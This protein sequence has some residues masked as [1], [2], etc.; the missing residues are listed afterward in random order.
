MKHREVFGEARWLSPRSNLDAAL[1]R[2]EIEIKNDFQKA[3]L[4]VCGL[5]WFIFFINGKRVGS[6]EFVPAYSDYHERPNM[7]LVYPLN[8]EQTHRI[9]VMKYDV[10]KYLHTG[11]NILAAAV[12]GGYYHQTVRKA[13]G[14]MNYGAIKL[15]YK[16]DVDGE[17]FYSNRKD[18]VF[19]SGFF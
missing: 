4:T 10:T 16:L 17:S 19:S 8:D 12:G 7:D 9:Y 18:V 15:C 11:K 13:E 3:E 14:N 2:S 5:G 1:F 6:D